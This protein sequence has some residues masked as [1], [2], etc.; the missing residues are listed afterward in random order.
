MKIGMRLIKAYYNV[1]KCK[2]VKMY[3]I[4]PKERKYREEKI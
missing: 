1:R 3:W 2:P 4:V